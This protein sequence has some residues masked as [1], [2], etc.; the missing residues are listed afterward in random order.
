MINDLLMCSEW[1]EK[2]MSQ[3]MVTIAKIIKSQALAV[4]IRETDLYV[5]VKQ[6]L[7]RKK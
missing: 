1:C 4:A 7:H 5:N 6:A 3:S 2:K